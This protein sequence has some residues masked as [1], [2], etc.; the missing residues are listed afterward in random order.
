MTNEIERKFSVEKIPDEVGL[1]TG[2]ELR[3]GYVALDGVVEVRV[4]VT[5]EEA[6]LTVKAGAGLLR[7]E[8]EAAISRQ[9]ADA[10]WPHA[11]GRQVVKRRH[12]VV[13]GRHLA[14]V[15]VYAGEL[16]GLCTAE[17]EFPTQ[18]AATSFEP[19][20]WF[21]RE[22]TGDGRWSNAAL[23]RFGIPR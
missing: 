9:E 14:D 6:V 18:D 15:D 19:P 12:K 16:S 1:E 5:A 13:V 21:A 3:Q 20:P 7:T 17:V 10:L 8:V 23:A 2:V 4:R 11:A 22:V